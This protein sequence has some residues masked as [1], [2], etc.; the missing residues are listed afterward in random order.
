MS[1]LLLACRFTHF[2]PHLVYF[3]TS[4]TSYISERRSTRVHISE[5]TCLSKISLSYTIYYYETFSSFLAKY[6]STF[7][8]CSF[9]GVNKMNLHEKCSG[10]TNPNT[11][12]YSYVTP[13]L[14]LIVPGICYCDVMLHQMIFTQKF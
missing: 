3:E 5:W 10:I 14:M 11:S 1:R 7:E 6:I 4:K 12:I 8:K 9:Q 2:D 13:Q